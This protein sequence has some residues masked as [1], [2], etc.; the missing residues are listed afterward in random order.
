MKIKSKKQLRQSGLLIAIVLIFL[1][2]ILPYLFHGVTQ[3]IPIFIALFISIISLLFPYKLIRPINYWIKIGN[4]LGKVN[5]ILILWIFFYFILVPAS[6][7][8]YL[9]KAF[10]QNKKDK[11]ISYYSKVSSKDE[12]NLKDQY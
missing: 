8:R 6:F 11:R 4:F 12:S 5:S 2:T 10:S 3:I 9:I 1:F 7:I